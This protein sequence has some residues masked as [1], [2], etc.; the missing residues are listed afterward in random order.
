MRVLVL[1]A[2]LYLVLCVA[3][4]GAATR[5]AAPGGSGADPC[6]N[7]ANP[8]SIYTAADG[9]APGTT[10]TAGDVVMLAPGQYSDSAGDLGVSGFVNMAAGITLE[11]QPGKPRP[12][13]TLEA[14]GPALIAGSGATASHLEITSATANLGIEVFTGGVVDDVI[15]TNSKS[16]S[17]A[18]AQLGG[19][20][21]DSVC[22]S[23]GSFSTAVGASDIGGGPF[24][25]VLRNVTAIATGTGSF[26]VSYTYFKNTVGTLNGQSVIAEGTEKDV[27]AFGNE[28]GASSTVQLEHSDFDTSEAK[29]AAGGAAS[30]TAP[31][32]GTNITALPLFAADGFHE[33]ATSP[34]VDKGFVDGSSGSADNDGQLRTIGS[35]P[36]IGAD[37]LAHATALAI[38]C[39]PETL[40][41]AGEGSGTAK[42]PTTVTD[43]SPG[44]TAPTGPLKFS[45]DGGIIAN[46]CTLT[47]VS[48]VASSCSSS[49]SSFASG[50]G[51]HHLTA[52]YEGDSS[53]D[54][55]EGTATINLVAP[56]GGGAGGGSGGG[57]GGTGGGSEKSHLAPATTLGKHP[58]KRGP[59]QLASFTFGSDQPGSRFECKLDKGKFKPCG[60]PF[61]RKVPV[62]P[63]DFRVRAVT[64]EGLQDATPVAFRWTR[65]RA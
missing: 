47:A 8:C 36:D 49:W 44:A 18:C 39:S 43:T 58:P 25:S 3:S 2:L 13:I 26:G 59:R 20:I 7:P 24:N 30:V 1:T 27:R 62:G 4:A 48:A 41:A 16:F 15:V 50:L 63:H 33:L 17:F 53:H 51:A 40:V 45:T 42:C 38:T 14:S 32:A 46:F 56:P 35:A 37:E 12:L 54:G 55:S 52:K 60:S 61:K 19:V 57:G 64:A 34:T 31:G 10:V 11:G 22:L 9:G 65:T 28:G 6:A 23:S 5:Y 29:T 21:R